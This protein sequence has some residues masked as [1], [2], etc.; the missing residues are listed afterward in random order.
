MEKISIKAIRINLEMT[1]KEM[2]DY[3][4]ISLRAYVDKENGVNKFYFD[5]VKKIADLGKV[6]LDIIR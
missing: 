6:S 5:E 3:L 4:N 2:A 1:Q